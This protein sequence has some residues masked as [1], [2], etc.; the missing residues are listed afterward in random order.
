MAQ[1]TYIPGVYTTSLTLNNS[2]IDVEVVV[3]ENHINSVRLVHID[4]AVTT[5]FPLVEPAFDSIAGQIDEGVA[6]ENITY[7]ENNRYT[8]QAL[9][10]AIQASLDKASAAKVSQNGT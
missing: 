8:S 7:D 2:V 4:E 5:M 10:Q 3:D 6:I 9:L 1:T